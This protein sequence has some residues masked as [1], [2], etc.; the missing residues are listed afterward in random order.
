[1]KKFKNEIFIS[2]LWN[3]AVFYNLAFCASLLAIIGQFSQVQLA[4]LI[5]SLVTI[6]ILMY[7]QVALLMIIGG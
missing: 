6:S 1:M 5:T 3:I 4:I 2:T 7:W